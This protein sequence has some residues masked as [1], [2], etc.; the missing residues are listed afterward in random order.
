MLIAPLYRRRGRERREKRG[1]EFSGKT[2][3]GWAKK[4][5]LHLIVALMAGFYG[6]AVD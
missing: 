4:S 3:K 1:F 6:H 2:G 5:G